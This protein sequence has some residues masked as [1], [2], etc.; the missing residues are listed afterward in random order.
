MRSYLP[1]QWRDT[2]R[3]DYLRRSGHRCIKDLEMRLGREKSQRI[4]FLTSKSRNKLR[5]AEKGRET[6]AVQD[7]IW[8]GI[9]LFTDVQETWIS[10]DN[11]TQL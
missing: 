1:Q 4:L 11:I 10:S 3:D 2:S 6:Y 9:F 7:L 5:M 8:Q